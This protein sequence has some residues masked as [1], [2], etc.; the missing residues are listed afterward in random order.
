MKYDKAVCLADFNISILKP[1]FLLT[2]QV[3]NSLHVSDLSQLKR[4]LTI[5]TV[6]STCTRNLLFITYDFIAAAELVDT[7]IFL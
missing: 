1:D 5:I 4:V 2:Y 6:T 3:I 7:S